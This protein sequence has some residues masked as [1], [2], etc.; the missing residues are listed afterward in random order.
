[1]LTGWLVADCGVP[2]IQLSEH[3][4]RLW[5]LT[6]AEVPVCEEGPPYPAVGVDLDSVGV[7]VPV[8]VYDN[9]SKM[10][11]KIIHAPPHKQTKG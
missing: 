11:I 1:M 8:C 4:E 9:D 2:I 7:L 5:E 3:F 10:Q 6:V